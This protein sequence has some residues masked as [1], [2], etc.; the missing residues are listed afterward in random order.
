MTMRPAARCMP[1]QAAVVALKRLDSAERKPK[2]LLKTV[3]S[4][5]DRAFCSLIPDDETASKQAQKAL[6]QGWYL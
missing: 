2:P 5:L 6:K 4:A 3:L 1:G